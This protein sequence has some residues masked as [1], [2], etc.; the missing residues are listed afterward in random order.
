V[1]RRGGDG[2]DYSDLW[3]STATADVS[4]DARRR[5]ASHGA[6]RHKQQQQQQQRRTQQ[7]QQSLHGQHGQHGQH[8]RHR[9]YAADLH[10]HVH[11]HEH[12]HERAALRQRQR[13]AYGVGSSARGV[14]VSVS[15]TAPHHRQRRRASQRPHTAHRARSHSP[16]GASLGVDD[17]AVLAAAAAAEAAAVSDGAAVPPS[18]TMLNE[19]N[20]ARIRSRV[21]AQDEADAR[22]RLQVLPSVS[23]DR[24]I[25][26]VS[27]CRR[28]LSYDI[29]VALG[30]PCR[31][32]VACIRRRS[33]CK[34]GCT[35]LRCAR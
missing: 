27:S 20:A 16:H 33:T 2:D 4:D 26:F 22:A 35:L 10:V 18:R 9:D 12:E 3:A 15:T 14:S 11:E 23:L 32:V 29:H 28:A 21:D 31:A 7:S 25:V 13:R 17:D 19:V 24:K 34:C 30:V 8:Q 1:Q 5:S 6:R